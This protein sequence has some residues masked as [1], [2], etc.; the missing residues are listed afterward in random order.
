MASCEASLGKCKVL[1]NSIKLEKS[2]CIFF[3]CFEDIQ[4]TYKIRVDLTFKWAKLS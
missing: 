1:Q 3:N 2:F 4:M